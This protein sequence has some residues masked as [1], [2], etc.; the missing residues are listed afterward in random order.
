M[1]DELL[2]KTLFFD[3]DQARKVIVAWIADYNTSRPHSALNYPTPAASAAELTATG[4]NA[5]LSDGSWP[6]A[7]PARNRIEPAEGLIATG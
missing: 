3:L 6:V 1:R 7:L 4:L 5:A 2:N